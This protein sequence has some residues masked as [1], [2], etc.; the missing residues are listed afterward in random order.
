MGRKKGCN[1]GQVRC[2]RS[3]RASTLRDP[4]SS[5]SRPLK[6]LQSRSTKYSY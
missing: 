1:A 6:E 5:D 2:Q 3:D 4:G